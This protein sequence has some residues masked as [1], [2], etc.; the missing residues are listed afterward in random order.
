[1]PKEI[2]SVNTFSISISSTPFLG[3]ILKGEKNAPTPHV[4]LDYYISIVS[5]NNKLILVLFRYFFL[6]KDQQQKRVIRLNGWINPI[7]NFTHP[8]VL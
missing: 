4:K 3:S 1:M 7:K 8:R 5:K 6:S 2:I